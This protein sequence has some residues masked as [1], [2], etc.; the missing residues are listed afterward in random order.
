MTYNITLK[1]ETHISGSAGTPWTNV[2]AVSDGC[3]YKRIDHSRHICEEKTVWLSGGTTGENFKKVSTSL[4]AQLEEM[5]QSWLP[6]GSPPREKP[7]FIRRLTALCFG[8]RTTY[9]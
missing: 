4:H 6:K 7:N 5:Y 9:N 3:F 8:T 2:F 1:I